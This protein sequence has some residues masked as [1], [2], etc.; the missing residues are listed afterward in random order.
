MERGEAPRSLAIIGGS[1]SSRKSTSAS[2]L[3]LLRL[4]RTEPSACSGATPIAVST[5]LGASEPVVHAE[6][7]TCDF[8]RKCNETPTKLPAERL[9]KEQ[10]K[11]RRWAKRRHSVYH[12][13]LGAAYAAAGALLTMQV[14]S[15]PTAGMAA[16]F[17]G[18][19]L[20][21][22]LMRQVWPYSPQR[23]RPS[24]GGPHQRIGSDD[25]PSGHVQ[26]GC[27]V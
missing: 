7:F 25:L 12:S 8:A 10:P 23:A 9:G 19:E 15:G 1:F 14:K 21:V 6:R 27:I 2:V 11:R 26:S 3:Y 13:L 24:P 5:W 22:G 16:T 18:P 20:H 17:H 4:K